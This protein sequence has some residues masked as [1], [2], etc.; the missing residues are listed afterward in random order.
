MIFF[1]KTRVLFVC[2]GNLCRSPTAQAVF[3]HL[4]AQARLGR[5]IAALS[6]GTHVS[7]SGDPPDARAVRAAARRGYDM[8]RMRTR[9]LRAGDYKRYDYL[10]AMDEHNLAYLAQDCPQ[11]YLP[12][13]ELFM[14]YGAARESVPIADPYYGPAQGFERVLDM[15]EDA[16]QGLLRHICWR[17]AL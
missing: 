16:A 9:P 1:E 13:A 10:L 3:T 11:A 8:S 17:K 5:R 2:T 14:R 12:K 7:R 15:I 4:V 6:A